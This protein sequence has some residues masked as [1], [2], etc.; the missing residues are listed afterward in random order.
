MSVHRN[1]T[2]RHLH[3]LLYDEI[4]YL[5]SRSVLIM[6]YF[7][8][9][10]EVFESS[11]LHAAHVTVEGSLS[12]MN[13]PNVIP[14]FTALPKTLTTNLQKKPYI[15]QYTNGNLNYKL[16]VEHNVEHT[17][18]IRPSSR[19]KGLVLYVSCSPS[20]SSSPTHA[21]E[22]HE[23]HFHVTML[24]APRD[25]IFQLG[26]KQDLVSERSRNN[27]LSKANDVYL[28]DMHIFVPLCLILLCINLWL[29]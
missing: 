12:C 20:I 27:Y 9:T 6:C 24:T 17:S 29:C 25:I 18:W 7:D 10:T 4:S 19:G 16:N 22:V 13:L 5:A 2:Q 21:V 8:V 14:H 3:V 26:H 1:T 28:A 11:K 15:M 23:V